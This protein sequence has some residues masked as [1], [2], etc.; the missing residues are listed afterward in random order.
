MILIEVKIRI[1]ILRLKMGG[2]LRFRLRKDR[3][4]KKIKRICIVLAIKIRKKIMDWKIEEKLGCL[5][6]LCLG[7]E[8][9]I[10]KPITYINE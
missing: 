6:N 9:I 7:L 3:N 4:G 10:I 8:I 5:S 1:K 2:I